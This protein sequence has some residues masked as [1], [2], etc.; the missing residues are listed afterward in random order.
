MIW[1]IA[2]KE[3]LEY[4][5]S[6]RF[7][8]GFS[9]T[10]ALTVLS[11][12]MNV[13]DFKARQDDCVSAQQEIKFDGYRVPI[14]RTPEV[15]SVLVE[16]KDRKLGNNAQ[17][18][19]MNVPSKTSGYMGEYAS[20]HHRYVSGFSSVDFAFVVRI[21]M[22]LLVIFLMYTAISE[23]KVR[24]TLK[25]SLANPLPRSTLLMG[26]LTGGLITVLLS[27]LVAFLVSIVI[28]LVNPSVALGTEE[29]LRLGA[30]FGI[31][32]LYLILF[33]AM[34]LFVS[35]TV[36]RP[37]V[38]LTVLLQIWVFLAIVYPQ[39]ATAVIENA[40]KLP[41]Q[42]QLDDR[43]AAASLPFQKEMLKVNEEIRANMAKGNSP[44]LSL[45]ARL[46]DLGAKQAEA[47]Y[48]VD[49][50]TNNRMNHQLALVNTVTILS[51]MALYDQVAVRFSRTGSEEFDLFVAAVK[52]YWQVYV[53]MSK[54]RF[55]NPQAP[56]QKLP[57]FTSTHE[58]LGASFVG[59]S[60]QII[61][62]VLLTVMF[63]A[64]A[65]ARFLRKDVR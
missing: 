7:V 26:K 35:V 47:R 42:E 38:A 56:R 46:T 57:P 1:I 41:T 14:Y 53:D 8:I 9:V 22:S 18:D 50:E 25:L 58:S 44:D 48:G 6:L 10:I 39:I 61:I 11:T 37:S 4:L 31:S 13:N 30:V 29:W 60:V 27:L 45:I 20:Q 16:G 24:G 40:Y 49:M 65:Y 32:A 51:P 64:L 28:L 36:N 23:E 3:L 63:A 43:K 59:S 52:R 17:I 19:P 62:L 5:K 33:F 21:V 34:S 12:V 2:R 55:R 15:L 54:E